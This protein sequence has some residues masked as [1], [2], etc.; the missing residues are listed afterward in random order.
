MVILV[1]ADGNMSTFES[2]EKIKETYDIP[3]ED[4][5]CFDVFEVEAVG[6]NLKTGEKKKVI[7]INAY[8]NDFDVK[9]EGE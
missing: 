9:F 6:V 7:E 5:Q 3:D 4:L 2:I 1:D 8:L